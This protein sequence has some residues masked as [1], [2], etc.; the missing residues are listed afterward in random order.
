MKSR[1]RQS[2]HT[3]RKLSTILVIVFTAAVMG[4]SVFVVGRSPSPHPST[5]ALVMAPKPA[6]S[7]QP[8]GQPVNQHA[9]GYAIVRKLQA[10]A[11]T[12][13]VPLLAGLGSSVTA[14]DG[15]PLKYTPTRQLA[16][17][18]T[19]LAGLEGLT[20][21]VNGYSGQTLAGMDAKGGIQKAIE[22]KP[23]VLIFE[24]CGL[25]E[26]GSSGSVSTTERTLRLQLGRLRVALPETLI[27]VTTPSAMIDKGPNSANATYREYLDGEIAVA[28]TEG[29]PVLDVERVYALAVKES[30][31]SID[32][33]LVDGVHGNAR[34]YTLWATIL[35]TYVGLRA[36]PSAAVV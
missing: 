7:T 29:F 9:P 24:A 34:G 5:E 35:E 14:G 28:K 21:E 8:S 10:V 20:V 18:L 17:A 1:S 23:D 25:N 15:A 12:G 36:A 13:R 2:R 27:V 4:L 19:G 30:Q 32:A 31:T 11:E 22:Q 33:F 16:A 3:H 6:E 26:Y